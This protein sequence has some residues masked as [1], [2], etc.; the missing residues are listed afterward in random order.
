MS[1][2]NSADIAAFNG[3]VWVFCEQRQGTMMP[4]SFELISEGRKLAD[5]RGTK[6]YGLLLGDGIEG[7]AKELGGYGAD[8]VYVCDHPLLK[9]YTT[10]GYT[11]VICDTVME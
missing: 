1:T 10:D 11:K 5:E 9:E 3:G 4:T 6:L 8:G 7:I 2:F